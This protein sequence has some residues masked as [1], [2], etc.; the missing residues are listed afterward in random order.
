MPQ[1]SEE[2]KTI[3]RD[4][5]HAS[6]TPWVNLLIEPKIFYIEDKYFKI[7]KRSLLERDS[8]LFL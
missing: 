2:L 7:L 3:V 1:N 4:W 5:Y 6:T 8:G